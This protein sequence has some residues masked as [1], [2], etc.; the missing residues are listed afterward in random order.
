MRIAHH[1][2]AALLL[3]TC[4]GALAGCRWP[5]ESAPTR[6]WLLSSSAGTRATETFVVSV[7]IGPVQLPDYLNRAEL[8][9]RVG[10]NELLAHN[11]DLWA[12]RLD[13]NF[14]D[15][16]ADDLASLVPGIAVVPFPWKGPA[17]V[18]YRLAVLVSRFEFDQA[19][20]EV[21]LIG[22][23][24]L[25][26]AAGARIA[27]EGQTIILPV[28]G[29]D[30]EAITAGMSLAVREFAKSIATELQAV[31]ELQKDSNASDG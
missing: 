25:S 7:G 5:G 21:V 13:V 22:G 4:L 11:F 23:W 20:N 26:Q 19:R 10:P 14:R 31:P 16:L 27:S 8:I 18:E 9:E 30:I 6:H 2:M 17:A 1:G 15:V 24:G 29:N 12:E 28:E 3:L